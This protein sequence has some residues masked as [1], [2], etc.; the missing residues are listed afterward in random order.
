MFLNP[1]NFLNA[2]SFL[3]LYMITFSVAK[4]IKSIISPYK[5]NH[6]LTE[7]NNTAL[8]VSTAGY[9]IGVT[10]VYVG[11]YDGPSLPEWWQEVLHVGGYSL[12]GV[13]LLNLSRFINDKLILYKFSNNKEIIEDQNIGT[14]FIQAAS[15]T[16]SGLIIGG[17][18]HSEGGTLVT[19]L[20]FFIFGQVCLILFALLYD[21]LTPYS[22]HGEIE[23]K[24]TA[25]GMGFA[26]GFIAIGIIVM[27]GVSGEFVSWTSNLSNLAFNI[28]LL[29]IYLIFVRFFFD[30]VIIP[31]ADL[32]KL[33]SVDKNLSAGTLE[34]IIAISFST[35]LFFIIDH[36]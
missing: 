20:A 14:G 22:V 5:L 19:S 33:I 21:W 27:K 10:A 36:Q 28:E 26:G 13:V 8:G 6:E 11:V 31:H 17:T 2:F 24:N 3:L 23:N 34:F 32:N 18:L 16:A 35:V 4:F 7:K 15:Y 25:A 1:D 12:L 9:F 29:F 30:K